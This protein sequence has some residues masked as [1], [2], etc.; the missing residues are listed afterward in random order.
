MLWSSETIIP[1]CG[2]RGPSSSSPSSPSASAAEDDP[3][4][5]SGAADDDGAGRNRPWTLGMVPRK[6]QSVMYASAATCASSPPPILP[7]ALTQCLHFLSAG[8]PSVTT[9]PVSSI[10]SFPPLS[11]A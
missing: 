5:L 1:I 10:A 3:F 2:G 9:T 4:G 7:F 11:L 8:G 6:N